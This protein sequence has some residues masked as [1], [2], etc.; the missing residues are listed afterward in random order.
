MSTG[1]DFVDLA[2]AAGREDLAGRIEDPDA[3]IPTIDLGREETLGICVTGGMRPSRE[4]AVVT[5]WDLPGGPVWSLTRGL[6][7]WS[8]GD[9]DVW[10]EVIVTEYDLT[11]PDVRA[12]VLDVVAGL[13]ADEF[14]RQWEA[15]NT[16]ERIRGEE[17]KH[18]RKMLSIGLHQW[19]DAVTT[20][21]TLDPRPLPVPVSGWRQL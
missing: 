4:V 1:K 18:L 14:K 17:P 16:Q 3:P 2:R 5:Y 15:P 11:G 10:E 19:V 7:D 12:A 20:L 6:V 9:A 8:A 13:G 21:R